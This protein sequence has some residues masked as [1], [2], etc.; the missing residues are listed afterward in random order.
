MRTAAVLAMVSVCGCVTSEEHRVRAAPGTTA[1]PGLSEPS[2]ESAAPGDLESAVASMGAS[3]TAPEAETRDAWRFSVSPFIWLPG[4]K[5]TTAGKGRA[6]AAESSTRDLVPELKFAA[7]LHAEAQH[8]RFFAF[9]EYVRFDLSADLVDVL[10]KFSGQ[11][12]IDGDVE[13]RETLGLVAAGWRFVE[14]PIDR[15]DPSMLLVIEGYGGARY[16]AGRIAVDADVTLRSGAT[17]VVERE[18]T[19]SW[20]DPVVGVRGRAGMWP[21]FDAV[22]RLEFGGFGVGAERTAFVMLGADWKLSDVTSLQGG[23]AVYAFRYVEG[24]SFEL[25]EELN[26]PYLAL[27]IRF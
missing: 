24:D 14:T 7:L 10:P 15:D 23:W 22:G 5:L 3:E 9:A 25:K 18:A 12:A 20:W 21:G 26:G 13:V 11:S 27:T 16:T 8:G 6:Q 4:V 17:R 19:P 1:Q 2:A